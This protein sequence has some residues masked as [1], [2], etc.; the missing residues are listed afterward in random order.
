MFEAKNETTKEA[1][2]LNGPDRL[3]K[4]STSAIAARLRARHKLTQDM[5]TLVIILF[6]IEMVPVMTFFVVASVEFFVKRGHDFC[7]ERF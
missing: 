5:A 6:T 7:H 1:T 3:P 2:S 4:A